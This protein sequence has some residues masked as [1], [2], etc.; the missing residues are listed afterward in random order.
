M[1]TRI[2]KNKIKAFGGDIKD[3]I[4]SIHSESV[5]VQA[6][7]QKQLCP[8]SDVEHVHLNETIAIEQEGEDIVKVVEGDADHTYWIHVEYGTEDQP[9]QQH[10]RPAH[11]AAV[12]HKNER[13]R[14]LITKY[15]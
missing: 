5:K 8:E 15:R 12:K 11:A 2:V 4:K 14:S 13:L 3:V 10:I 1:Q 7:L 6:S 9:A